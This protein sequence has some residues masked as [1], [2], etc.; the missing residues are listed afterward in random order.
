MGYY[1]FENKEY[2]AFV[3]DY[4]G[5]V[6]AD[7]TEW[8][9]VVERSDY[10]PYGMQM[11]VPW[12]TMWAQPYKFMGKELDRENGWDSYDVHARWLTSPIAQWTTQD[13]KVEKYFSW[14]PYSYCQGDPVNRIDK[15]GMDT[16]LVDAYGNIKGH[17]KN[18]KSDTFRVVNDKGEYV[19]S[20]SMKYG[21]IEH[22]STQKTRNGGFYDVYKVRGDANS[23]R[24]FEFMADNTKVEWSQMM[25]G[26]KGSGPSY[27]TTSHSKMSEAGGADLF[28]RQ[29]RHGYTYREDNHN[30][31]RGSVV[32]SVLVTSD[33]IPNDGDIPYAKSVMI[34]NGFWYTKFNV[35]TSKGTY[36]PYDAFSVAGDFYEIKI[37][38]PEI[39]VIWKHQ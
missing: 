27:I 15:N 31:P 32:P 26:K 38:I 34:D 14:S 20:M 21:S 23:K 4:R 33:V 36:T 6:R 13:K 3:K 28:Y 29:I 8:E 5:N 12:T 11:R 24:L 37:N 25:L 1:N 39:E 2:S 22:A 30:H 7:V 16:W 10:Y 18:R 19:A 17:Y 9:G 35:Y